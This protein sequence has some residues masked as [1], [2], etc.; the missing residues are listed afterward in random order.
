MIRRMINKKKGMLSLEVTV[1]LI[2]G[3]LALAAIM[4]MIFIHTGNANTNMGC[5]AKGG[6][7]ISIGQECEGTRVTLQCPRKDNAVQTCCLKGG[8]LG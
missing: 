5:E 1:M 2:I 8:L 4:Y 7:C 6:T 3:V